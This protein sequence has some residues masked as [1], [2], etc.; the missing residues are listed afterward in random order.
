M[1]TAQQLEDAKPDHQDAGADLDLS[2]P[3]DEDDQY[4]KRKDEHE[5]RKQMSYREWPKCSH[6]SA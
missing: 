6:E 5:E 4:R 1:M 3:S 2:R